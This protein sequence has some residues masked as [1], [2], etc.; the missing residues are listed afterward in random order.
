MP[1]SEL[2]T[3]KWTCRRFLDLHGEGGGMAAWE[4]QKQQG[5]FVAGPPCLVLG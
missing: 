1:F 2:S 3:K 5:V 4:C